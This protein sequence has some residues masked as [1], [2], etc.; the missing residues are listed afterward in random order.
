MKF[1]IVKIADVLQGE[2]VIAKAYENLNIDLNKIRNANELEFVAKKLEKNVKTSINEMVTDD[3]GVATIDDLSVGVYLIYSKDNAQYENITPFL[4]SIPMF[5]ETEAIMEYDIEVYPKH[6]PLTEKERPQTPQ[7]GIEHR[8][9]E[10]AIL[11]VG[12]LLM[13]LTLLFFYFHKKSQGTK[14]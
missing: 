9:K 14:I 10:Y 1:G 13:A 4:I 6:T 12:L 2:F 5:C 8:A 11:S 3:V 7:T